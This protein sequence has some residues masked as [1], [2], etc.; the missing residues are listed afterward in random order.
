MYVIIAGLTHP[1]LVGKT[2]ASVQIVQQKIGKQIGVQ[3]IQ[4]L[5]KQ[6]QQA[7]QA[8]AAAQQQA[9]A[10][11]QHAQ[12]ITA[13]AGTTVSGQTIIATTQLI[14]PANMHGK[15]LSMLS[16]VLGWLSLSPYGLVYMYVFAI[17]LL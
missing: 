7:Q 4:Q 2:G 16:V 6:Q 1:Q 15:Q 13:P 5:I 9:A 11:Q 17:C 8:A 3:Q 12:I 14:T 10:A